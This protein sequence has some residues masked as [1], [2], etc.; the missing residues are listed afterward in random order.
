MTTPSECP[1]HLYILASSPDH[2]DHWL[3][4]FVLESR[5]KDGKPY[6]PNVLHQL[7][8]GILRYVRD[9]KPTIDFFQRQGVLAGFRCTLDVLETSQSPLVTDVLPFIVT[10]G[11]FYSV[12]LKCGVIFLL[13]FATPAVYFRLI[14]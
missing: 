10:L 1:A 2:F 8:C 12:V 6:P 7:V 11:I 13:F 9:L 5:R 3:A 14:D 4:R